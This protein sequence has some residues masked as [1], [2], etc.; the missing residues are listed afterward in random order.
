MKISARATRHLQIFAAVGVP[1]IVAAVLLQEIRQP[2]SP[3]RLAAKGAVPFAALLPALLLLPAG[4]LRATGSAVLALSAMGAATLSCLAVFGVP[5]TAQVLLSLLA[6]ATPPDS[7]PLLVALG[8]LGTAVVV[9]RWRGY[10][11][12][13]STS[14]ADLAIGA[15]EAVYFGGFLLASTTHLGAWS[16]ILVGVGLALSASSRGAPAWRALGGATAMVVITL[17]SESA[18][19]AFLTH[20]ALLGS[21]GL[22]ESSGVTMSSPIS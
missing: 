12:S 8:I 20:S 10:G 11:R 14:A 15:A 2:F 5:L 18:Y 13:T 21:R 22:R 6:L 1:I 4:A 16:W 7:G 3:A 9:R 17:W 19:V